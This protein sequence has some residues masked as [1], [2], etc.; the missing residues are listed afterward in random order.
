MQ[1]RSCGFSQRLEQ[2]RA[3]PR[4]F[5]KVGAQRAR[6]LPAR[7]SSAAESS[8]SECGGRAPSHLP[9][10]PAQVRKRAPANEFRRAVPGYL[11]RILSQPVWPQ[12]N[13]PE[14]HGLREPTA[15][16]A[17]GLNP[18]ARR[19][20]GRRPQRP[21]ARTGDAK[22]APTNTPACVYVAVYAH[23]C[24][25][26]RRVQVTYTHVYNSP[27]FTMFKSCRPWKQGAR[28]SV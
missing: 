6:F 17:L 23:L 22:S 5:H 24:V 7:R 28:V 15:R 26:G 14:L 10:P 12:R 11:E 27:C 20:P 16:K 9:R 19:A 25:P 1:L 21:R 13:Q 4:R 3:Y 2:H 18:S 8:R